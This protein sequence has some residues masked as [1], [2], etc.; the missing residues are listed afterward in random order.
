VTIGLS[1]YSFFWQWHSTAPHPLSLLDMVAKTASWGI[2]LLQVCDYP[3]VEHY[4]TDQLDELA[5][6]GRRHGVTFEL[7]TRSIEPGHLQRY[8]RLAERLEAP[9][10]RSMITA[11]EAPGAVDLLRR[12]TSAFERAGVT[13]ALETYEQVPTTRLVEIV[14]QVGSPRLGIC[15][16]P[17]NSVAA[18]ETP[19]S[20]VELS[21]PHTVNLHVKDFA[22]TRQQGWVGFTLAGARLGEGQLDVDHLLGAVRPDE[23]GISKIIEHWLVWQGDSETT[24]RT[25]DEW[26]EH[27]LAFL[28]QHERTTTAVDQTAEARAEGATT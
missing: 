16:D 20:T 26:T 12:T 4:G 24:C 9:L 6:A 7:G 1:T 10:V 8:L 23:R 25:E 19:R 5:A 27:N 22:F 28:R 17:A 3:A 11:A 21:A 2:S 14:E 18:L 13:L 15:L